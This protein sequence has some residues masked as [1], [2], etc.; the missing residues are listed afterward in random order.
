INK[1]IV[2]HCQNCGH[3]RT[4][5]HATCDNELLTPEG[6][7]QR[8]KGPWKETVA[9]KP[10]VQV[11][12][13]KKSLQQV[14]D[15][16]NDVSNVVLAMKNKIVYKNTQKCENWFGNRCPYYNA[17]HKGDYSGLKKRGDDGN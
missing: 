4:S 5:T 10:K 1:D 8:C 3:T 6:K 9:L 13:E 7:T 16:L 15:L 12:V 17:C 2:A 14:N 11:L